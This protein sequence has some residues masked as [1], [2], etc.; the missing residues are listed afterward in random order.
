MPRGSKAD[1]ESLAELLAELPEELRRQAFTHASW[2]EHR[3]ESYERLAFQPSSTKG[4]GSRIS[5]KRLISSSAPK[6][7]TI[8]S[9]AYLTLNAN[10]CERSVVSCCEGYILALIS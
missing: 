3:S 4:A 5:V 6:T 10:N 9:H 1:H 8:G 2:V 7:R